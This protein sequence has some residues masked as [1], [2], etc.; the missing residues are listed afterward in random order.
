[1]SVLREPFFPHRRNRDGSYDSI[2]LTC[3]A[4]VGSGTQEELVKRD[5]EHVCESSGVAERG[6]LDALSGAGATSG[7][8]PLIACPSGLGAK[9]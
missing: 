9:N 6:L 7:R 3:F 1:M 5:K 4:T 2:C 8:L